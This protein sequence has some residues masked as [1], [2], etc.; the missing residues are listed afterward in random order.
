MTKK[1]MCLGPWDGPLKAVSRQKSGGFVAA[2]ATYEAAQACVCV[3]VTGSNNNTIIM[4]QCPLC[5]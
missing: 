4:R 1:G 2:Y 5:R 3:C